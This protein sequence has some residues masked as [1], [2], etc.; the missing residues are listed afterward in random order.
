MYNRTKQTMLCLL[1][2]GSQSYQLIAASNNMTVLQNT[3][4]PPY[5][6]DPLYTYKKP[7]P[8][9]NTMMPDS[10]ITRIA[11]EHEDRSWCYKLFYYQSYK[12]CIELE[13][14]LERNASEGFSKTIL[15]KAHKIAERTTKI[16]LN[17]Y[18]IAEQ[19]Q[20]I[21]QIT[22]TAQYLRVHR[23]IQALEK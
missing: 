6:D 22:K 16:I 1:L 5:T 15:S 8:R 21:K 11:N 20:A 9:L 13:Q 4:Q 7:F 10:H 14:F 3:N 18:S 2:I 19:E 17:E 12:A 23:C